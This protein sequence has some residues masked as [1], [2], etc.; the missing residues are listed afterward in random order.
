MATKKE[1][2]EAGTPD[3]GASELRGSLEDALVGEALGCGSKSENPTGKPKPASARSTPTAPD[4][5]RARERYCVLVRVTKD[6]PALSQRDLRIPTHSWSDM[7]A[8]DICE[9]RI[10]CP[11]GTFKVQLLSDT[12]FLLRKLPTNG[13]ELSW[14]EATGIIRLVGGDYFWCGTP[15]TVSPGHRTKKEAKYDLQE[16]FGYRHTRAEEDV[17]IS[18]HRK[19]KKKKKS[20]I[21]RPA[22]PSRGRG[23]TRCSDKA[24]TKKIVGGALPEPRAPVC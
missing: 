21:N 7:I 5:L 3:A 22:T 11:S 2:I 16:T 18:Q 8:L 17:L 9:A 10:G 14:E 15:A 20:V 19:D 13:P 24:A 1:L 4:G 23:M 12:E 6:V